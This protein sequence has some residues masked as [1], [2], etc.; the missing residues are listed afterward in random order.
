MGLFRGAELWLDFYFYHSPN[1]INV[2][3][4]LLKSDI[5]HEKYSSVR[6]LNTI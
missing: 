2:N 3:L 6:N 1:K 4:S 5:L